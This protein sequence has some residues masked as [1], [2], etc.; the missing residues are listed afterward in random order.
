MLCDIR[1][2]TDGLAA[3]TTIDGPKCELVLRQLAL[4]GIDNPLTHTDEYEKESLCRLLEGLIK[5]T[6][7]G[8]PSR[9]VAECA[10]PVARVCGFE[11]P[12]N[13]LS[14]PVK[15]VG[16]LLKV[17]GLAQI[18]VQV[19][20]PGSEKKKRGRVYSIDATARELTLRHSEAQYQRLVAATAR[21]AVCVTDPL[22]T[23][24]GKT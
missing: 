6:T 18:G 11:V 24:G 13:I 22:I 20:V 8:D 10:A 7:D 17:I 23:V 2:L 5:N 4:F 12:K 9:W 14:D 15:W 16:K 3:R 21:E 1:R 19:R